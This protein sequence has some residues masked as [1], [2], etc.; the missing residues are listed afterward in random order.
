MPT[1]E[2]HC[3][4]C[5]NHF[6]EFQSMMN[7]AFADILSEARKYKLALTLANQYIEQMEEEV[8]DAVFG[9]VGTLI[10]FRVGPFDAE[11]LKVVFE[12]TFL[13]EDLVGLGVGQIY[14]TLMID[15]VGSAP[16]SAETI[17]P[18]ETPRISYRDDVVTHSRALYGRVRADVEKDIAQKQV[19]FAP[20]VKQ[21]RPAGAGPSQSNWKD[22]RP[23]DGGGSRPPMPSSSNAAPPRPPQSLG[24]D[25]RP[26]EVPRF[27]DHRVSHTDAPREPQRSEQ[28]PNTPNTLRA[29]IEAARGVSTAVSTVAGPT[30]SPA[31]ILRERTVSRSAKPP[32]SNPQ[33]HTSL[34]STENIPRDNLSY[35]GVKNAVPANAAQSSVHTAPPQTNLPAQAGEISSD[36]LQRVLKEN[37]DY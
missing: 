4:A 7:E 37:V 10:C 9:N 19:D 1:Y 30:R 23:S 5:E 2:Y 27:E 36:M 24:S 34:R 21:A 32:Q 13:A 33:P 15:G 12:P 18:I 22:K 11:V 14:L 25:P 35:E 26:R 29:A 28:S 31:D 6:D 17:P 20:P 3:D 8:R 16:F